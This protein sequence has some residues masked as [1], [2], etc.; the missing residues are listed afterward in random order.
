MQ[1]K[2]LDDLRGVLFDTLEALRD[3]EHPMDL[4]RARAIC[5]VSDRLI[6][7]AKVECKYVDLVGAAGPSQFLPQGQEQKP[8][9][10]AARAALPAGLRPLRS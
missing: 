9:R 7:T 4:D 2:N 1:T 3:K 5:E 10:G 8:D 6:D